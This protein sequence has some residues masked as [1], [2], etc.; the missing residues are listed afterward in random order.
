MTK[1]PLIFDWSKSES[2]RKDK[3]FS[4]IIVGL[5]FAFLI[6]AIELNLPSQRSD[7]MTQATLIR[8]VDE[9]MM[10]SWALEAQENGPFPGRLLSER[11]SES[12]MFAGEEGLAWW[13]DYEIQLRPMR[14]ETGVAS[15][16]I[17]PKGKQEF[18]II[19]VDTPGENPSAVSSLSEPILV[20]YNKEA[21]QWLP[22]ELPSFDLSR[23]AERTT[24]SLRFLVSLREDGSMAELIPLAGAV[25]QEQKTQEAEAQEAQEDWLR[26]IR[27]KKGI[28]ERWFG[29]RVDF[30]NRRDR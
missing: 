30:V 25:N 9:E 24:D 11:D 2:S 13:R 4:V 5:L 19:D 6:G 7:S 1:H 23:I 21:L 17:M 22:E 15:V 27:F 28:G 10:K 3:F 20:P 14:K 16:D 18:P 26:S 29:L 12:M 8:S